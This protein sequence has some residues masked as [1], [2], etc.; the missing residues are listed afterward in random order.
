MKNDNQNLSH[1]VWKYKRY[2]VFTPKYI[3]KII[4]QKYKQSIEKIFRELCG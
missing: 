3:R 1:T 2:F 4:Y